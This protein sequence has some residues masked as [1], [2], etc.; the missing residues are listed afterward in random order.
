MQTLRIETD[1]A[2]PL[3]R[4]FDLARSVEAHTASTS[5]TGERA[6]DGKTRGLL[7]LGDEVTWRGRHFGVTQEFTSR[8][9]QFERPLHFQDTMV[10][11]AFSRFVHDHSFLPVDAG[12]RMI[13]VVEFVAPLGVLGRVAE[14][15]LL[16]AYLKGVAEGQA[17][18]QFV[19]TG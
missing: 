7:V 3:D 2:A 9:T 15:T 11:G 14:V 18:R 12:T 1:I 19:T 5:R 13:D 10:R 8:I 16:A 6:V 17:W 4:C